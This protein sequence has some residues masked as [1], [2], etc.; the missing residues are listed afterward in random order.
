[1]TELSLYPSSGKAAT[2]RRPPVRNGRSHTLSG[3][4]IIAT[5]VLLP[6]LHRSA[7]ASPSSSAPA[8]SA[9]SSNA[10]VTV[11]MILL[12]QKSICSSSYRRPHTDCPKLTVTDVENLKDQYLVSDA[13]ELSQ[14]PKVARLRLTPAFQSALMAAIDA[15]EYA[16]ILEFDW[17]TTIT[18]V[19]DIMRRSEGRLPNWS[20][21]K[22]KFYRSQHWY[23]H[24]NANAFDPANNVIW[25]VTLNGAVSFL[26]RIE[27]AILKEVS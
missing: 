9:D 1:M 12:P 8:T 6:M 23:T 10:Q 27:S 19:V 25:Q 18:A 14:G 4:C 26:F 24:Q 17:G 16:V 5:L 20:N 15:N 3:S 2:C 11:R 7:W 13:Y 21:K 22:H